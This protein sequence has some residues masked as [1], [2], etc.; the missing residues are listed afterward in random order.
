M[1]E[2][3]TTATYNQPKETSTVGDPIAK[4][5][6]KLEKKE[7]EKNSEE[8]FPFDFSKLTA[9]QIQILQA[10][11][12]AQPHKMT[13][14]SKTNVVRLRRIGGKIVSDFK[15]A[16]TDLIDDPENNRKL[17]R[18]VIPI[19]FFGEE[20]YNIMLYSDFINA[21]QVSCEVMSERKEI[22]E[23]IEGEVVMHR[24]SGKLVDMVRRVSH[25]WYTIKL[26]SGEVVEI[27]ARLANG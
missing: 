8:T 27:E 26:P 5:A 1:D 10:K 7:D 6:E 4:V 18:H 13:R 19:K 22:E 9:E 3:K 11:L 21:E 16:Y 12:A 24:E 14:K 17:N 23:I 15:N 20:K 25:K 2:T